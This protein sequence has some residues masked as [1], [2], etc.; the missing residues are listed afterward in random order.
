MD[1]NNFGPFQSD[2]W[3]TVSDWVV[4]IVTLGTGIFLVLAFNEQRKTNQ[5]TSKQMKRQIL[6]KFILQYRND[7]YELSLTNA[8]AIEVSIENTNEIIFKDGFYEHIENFE[9]HHYP[10]VL[11]QI[12]G[13]LIHDGVRSEILNIFYS[14]IEGLEYSQTIYYERGLLFISTPKLK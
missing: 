10:I 14:D 4:I 6:P 2:V 5:L 3:G 7:R 12:D 9:L 8:P 11:P 1:I 13:S